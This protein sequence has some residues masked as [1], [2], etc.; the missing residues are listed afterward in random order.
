MKFKTVEEIAA[1]I[2]VRNYINMALDDATIKLPTEREESRKVKSLPGLIDQMI[3]SS[4]VDLFLGSKANGDD[5]EFKPE[6][7]SD[8][9][10]VTDSPIKKGSFKRSK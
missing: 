2:S 1:A 4:S 8:I 7:I 6:K 3:I 10:Q 5:Q 9:E